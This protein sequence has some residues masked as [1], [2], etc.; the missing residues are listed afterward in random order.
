MKNMYRVLTLFFLLLFSGSAMAAN[1]TAYFDYKKFW[2]PEDGPYIETYITI[3]GSSVNYVTQ[4]NGAIQAN[5]EITMI[6]KNGPEI[7][8]Y[9][10]YTLNSPGLVD[11]S[12]TDFIDQQRF[13]MKNGTYELEIEML[14]VNNPE[15]EA[16]ASVQTLEI[17]FPADE[18]NVSDIQLLDKVVKAEEAGPFTKSG[19]DL[20]PVAGNFYPENFSQIRFY[21]EIYNTHVAGEDERYLLRYYIE[22]FEKEKLLSDFHQFRKV[23]GQPVHVLMANLNIDKLGTGNYNLVVEVRSKEND[24][25]ARKVE[26]FQRS[27][28]LQE[29]DLEA[30]SSVDISETWVAAY[31]NIDTLMEHIRST[32]PL[33]TNSEKYIVDNTFKQNPDLEL[34]QQY[35]Y[36]FWYNRNNFEPE[37]DWEK[38]RKQVIKVEEMFGTRNKRGYETDRG[39]VY[40]KYGAP[41]TISDRPNEPSSYPYQIWHYYKVGVFNNKRFVFYS[42]QLVST[43]YELLHSD[44]PGELKDYRWRVRLTKRDNPA[45]NL[46]NANGQDHYGGRVDDFYTIPR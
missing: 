14:D 46:D 18:V 7:V 23:K 28:R 45:N 8:D 39:R 34:L 13:A 29:M 22:T 44:I 5:V 27:K 24:L 26:F 42:P 32:R 35:F 16:F 2:S 40:L 43:D 17:N 6:L 19:Y 11:S 9:K 12:Y 38:Y 41:N 10:K 4:Q 30:L 15:A 20:V 31:D 3:V 1:L 36:S 33:S 25:L 37:Q 21:T